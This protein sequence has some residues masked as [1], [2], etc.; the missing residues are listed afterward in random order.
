[1]RKSFLFALA[2]AIALLVS[3]VTC[4]ATDEPIQC[5]I[6]DLQHGG[7]DTWI[8]WSNTALYL[9]YSLRLK[10]AGYTGNEVAVIEAWAWPGDAEPEGEDVPI[11]R[12]AEINGGWIVESYPV[13]QVEDRC[14]TE[15]EIG[16]AWATLTTLNGGSGEEWDAFE[17]W[18][19][20]APYQ[21]QLRELVTGESLT[22][23]FMF[24]P[25]W[26][27]RVSHV[28]GHENIEVCCH[29]DSSWEGCFWVSTGS[30]RRIMVRRR[31]PVT[32]GIIL[33]ATVTYLDSGSPSSLA[34]FGWTPS[35]ER[36]FWTLRPWVRWERRGG[37]ER[38]PFYT[39]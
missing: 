29:G 7:W 18:W 34:E 15:S 35:L 37:M 23:P 20:S 31:M 30:P 13:I 4:V 28:A 17:N 2:L 9:P 21:R 1:M 26:N 5:D 38:A 12:F 36:Y 8:G 32:L 11:V 14:P 3:V 6:P 16:I 10:P 19:A 33:Q 27:I 22:S 24:P 25:D 39:K